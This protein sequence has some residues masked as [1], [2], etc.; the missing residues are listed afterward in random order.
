MGSE[1]HVAEALKAKRTAADRKENVGK[2]TRW[3]EPP[4]QTAASAKISAQ[5]QTGVQ[6]EPNWL[7]VNNVEIMDPKIYTLL[8]SLV[9]G[10]FRSGPP[11][12]RRAV[13]LRFSLLQ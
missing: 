6:G 10:A 2:G 12:L 1:G 11:S 3:E 8:L 13:L 4:H 5:V 7:L 9:C